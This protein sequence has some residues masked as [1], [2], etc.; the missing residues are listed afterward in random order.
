MRDKIYGTLGIIF[1]VPM[2]IALIAVPP[3]ILCFYMGWSFFVYEHVAGLWV[4]IM[5]SWACAIGYMK[6]II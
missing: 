1:G 6:G 4:L 3:A 5:F 2:L